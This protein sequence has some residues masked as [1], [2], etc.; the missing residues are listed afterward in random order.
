M[1]L[2][3]CSVLLVGMSNYQV[4]FIQGPP[5]TNMFPKKNTMIFGT[6]QTPD[7]CLPHDLSVHLAP[8]SNQR[9]FLSVAGGLCVRLSA[10][11][12]KMEIMTTGS[13]GFQSCRAGDCPQETCWFIG[14]VSGNLQDTFTGWWF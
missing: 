14:L 3:T 1:G 12:S 2:D 10:L 11:T 9:I 6:L 13:E 7:V 5:K 8:A 4:Y